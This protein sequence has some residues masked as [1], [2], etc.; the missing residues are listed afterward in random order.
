MR[1]W[2]HYGYVLFRAMTRLAFLRPA[3]LNL[4]LYH[5]HYDVIDY[6]RDFL[7]SPDPSSFIAARDLLSSLLTRGRGELV[8]RLGM[9]PARD[10]LFASGAT[11]AASA[12]STTSTSATTTGTTSA[13]SKA[14]AGRQDR[15]GWKDRRGAERGGAYD[16]DGEVKGCG[17]DMG[18]VVRPS[19]TYFLNPL[20]SLTSLSNNNDLYLGNTPLPL[21][22]THPLPPPNPPSPH[23]Q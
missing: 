6:H 15:R 20:P 17:E 21:P 19:R 22:N 9:H 18:A 7:A 14:S 12:T 5:S 2:R 8:I 16:D 10:L 11:N 3:H 1:S 4:T 23:P 13:T